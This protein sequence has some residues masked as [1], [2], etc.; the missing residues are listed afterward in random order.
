MSQTALS[1]EQIEDLLIYIGTSPTMWKGDNMQVCCPVHGESNP[2]MGVSLEKQKCHCFSCGFSGT[3][4]KLLYNA[5]PDEFG[6]D[7]STKETNKRTWFN[8]VRKANEFLLER[9][10]L[11]VRELNGKK[12]SRLKRYE[13]L[14][15]SIKVT[16]DYI[17]PMYEIATY[18]SGKETYRYFFDRGFTKK[19]MIK[20]KIGRDLDNKTVTLPVFNQEDKLLGVIG[21]FISSKRAKHERYKIYDKFERG[22][23]LYPLN[24]YEPKDNTII[25]VEGQFDAMSMHKKGFTNTLS[26]MT[27]NLTKPQVE[28]IVGNCSTVI[29]ICDNDTRGIAGRNI[30]IKM[31]GNRVVSKVVEYPDHGGDPCDWTKEEI[32]DMIDNA[33]LPL[34]AK[35]KRIE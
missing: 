4:N 19:D 10:E 34:K 21:R 30:N 32:Q 8:A 16:K 18:M 2:S 28:W 9:Y 6:Y 14:T 24:Y 23:T 11:E 13:E 17:I 29:H 3:F 26:N 22:N 31:L 33:K 7:G 20:Y 12:L 5:L 25:L 1:A 15:D 27:V 35:L